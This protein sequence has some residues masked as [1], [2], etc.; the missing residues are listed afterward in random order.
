[1]END[2]QVKEQALV[3]I[4]KMKQAFES[5]NKSNQQKKPALA[6]LMMLNEITKELRKKSL[7][8]HFID[9]GGVRALCF[10]LAPLPDNTTPNLK[11]LQEILQAID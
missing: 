7:Q 5:D 2:D 3:L 1:M 6:K 11:I 4:A 9:H 10:W 8:N